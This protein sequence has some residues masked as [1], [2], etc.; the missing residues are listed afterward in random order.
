MKDGKRAGDD[1]SRQM[2]GGENR[3]DRGRDDEGEKDNSAEP[4]HQRKQHEKAQDGHRLSIIYRVQRKAEEDVLNRYRNAF[5]D[6]AQ[7]LLGL[8]GLF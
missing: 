2:A 5:Y 4:D 1:Q 3:K 7:Y 8:F 6:F